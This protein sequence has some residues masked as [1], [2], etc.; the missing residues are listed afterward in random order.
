M[1]LAITAL[2]P[3]VRVAAAPVGSLKADHLL[4][5]TIY[6]NRSFNL[7]GN[8]TNVSD[9]SKINFTKDFSNVKN[10]SWERTGDFD[11]VT[12]SQKGKSM[13][14]YFG[15][16]S[17]LIGTISEKD[18]N[19]LPAEGRNEI[20]DQYKG[21]SIGRVINFKTYTPNDN[22]MV[23]FG[24]QIENADSYYVE[25]TKNNKKIVVRVNPLGNVS[26]FRDLT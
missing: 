16:Q 26:Y 5:L 10:V 11:V 15:M 22:Y 14:A 7:P 1:I 3:I 6:G 24:T 21:Y 2:V 25:L 4:R 18:Y 20:K 12:F 17:E 23:L 8:N 13:K 9:L 19:D